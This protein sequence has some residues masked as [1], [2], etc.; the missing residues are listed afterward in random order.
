M[1]QEEKKHLEKELG[2]GKIICD[3]CGA[4]LET[5]EEKC[6]AVFEG[7]CEGYVAIEVALLRFRSS[8]E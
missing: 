4:T 2:G 8:R 1:T 6:S 7:V 3:Q 5:Y